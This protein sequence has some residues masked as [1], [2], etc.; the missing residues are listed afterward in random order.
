MTRL[1]AGKRH[2]RPDRPVA[3][4]VVPTRVIGESERPVSARNGSAR[5]F[6]AQEN[7]T[8]FGVGAKF[9]KIDGLVP[10]KRR[11]RSLT[12]PAFRPEMLLGVGMISSRDLSEPVNNSRFRRFA[13]WLS[14]PRS[15]A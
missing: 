4:I 14:C 11:R 7:Q 3:E 10:E 15:I 5:S 6:P 8:P 12:G 9:A 1:I 13:S 2:R